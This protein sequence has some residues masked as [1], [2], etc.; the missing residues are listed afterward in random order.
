MPI[1]FGVYRFQ[2]L[3]ISRIFRKQRLE[4]AEEFR[5]PED[6]GG[7][8]GCDQT[9]LQEIVMDSERVSGGQLTTLGTTKTLFDC[10]V[11][12]MNED[13][14]TNMEEFCYHHHLVQTTVSVGMIWKVMLILMR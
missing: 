3:R 2:C 5:P 12:Y 10:D 14:A 8:S 13:S 4:A 6:G 11:S 1:W 7:I 9:I